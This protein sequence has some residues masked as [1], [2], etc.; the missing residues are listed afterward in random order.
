MAGYQI[1]NRFTA[2]LYS[3]IDGTQSSLA[4]LLRFELEEAP[5]VPFDDVAEVSNYLAA[6]IHGLKQFKEIP[7]CNRLIRERCTLSGF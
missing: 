2:V 3:Q 7:L 6:L 4:Q 5:G 1:G